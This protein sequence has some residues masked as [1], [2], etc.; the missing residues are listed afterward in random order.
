MVANLDGIHL[1]NVT[2]LLEPGES[3]AKHDPDFARSGLVAEMDRLASH[4][5]RDFHALLCERLSATAQCVFSANPFA[6]RRREA[7]EN[8]GFLLS[9][10]STCESRSRS[11]SRLP[12]FVLRFLYEIR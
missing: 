9:L 7:S 2:G 1:Q 6:S 4:C 10:T 8:A 3:R 11:Y 12:A 5:L